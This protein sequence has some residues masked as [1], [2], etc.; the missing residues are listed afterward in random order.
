MTITNLG[1]LSDQHLLLFGKIIQWFA[2]YELL[3]QEIM[4]VVAGS[5]SWVG[6]ALDSRPETLRAND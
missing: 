6:D 1:C 2:R 5:D 3:M 4:A